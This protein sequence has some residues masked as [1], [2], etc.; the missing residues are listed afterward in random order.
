M[1]VM[2]S[3][4]ITLLKW[5]NFFYDFRPYEAIAVLYFAQVTGSFALGLAIFSVASIAAMIFE[6]PTGVLSDRI[7]RRKTVIFGSIASVLAIGFYAFGGS[8][9]MLAIGAV[10][11]GLTRAFLSGNNDALLYDTLKQ[12]G[13]TD[14]FAEKLGKVNSMFE[15]GL[16]VSALL[17]VGLAFISLQAVV[18]ASVVPQVICALIALKF[19]EPKV[20]SEKI[21]EN[22][23]AHLKEALSAFKNNLKLHKL[24]LA[25]VLDYAFE[26][27]YFQFKP[28]FIATL[29]PTWA[30]GISRAIDNLFGFLGYHYA[31]RFVKRF[32]A[33]KTL[34]AQ[35]IIGRIILF[36]AAGLPTVASPLLQNINAFF[37]GVGATANGDL[38]QKEFTDKQRATMGSLNSCA[39]SLAFAIVMFGVGLVA[40]QIGPA[41]TILVLAV[42]SVSVI[43]IYANLFKKHNT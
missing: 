27:A 16:G 39:G 12:E 28:A 36:V 40:D 19:I 2:V 1:N 30:L 11:N 5:Y 33:L 21:E 7:G 29:W 31:G 43:V 4:N 25:Y 20:H 26:E 37:F 23:F 32:G 3:K 35:Q 13:K 38:M 15:V 9:A 8:F 6:V 24:S 22:V 41:K 17:A 14:A 42:L 10:F 34:F 18:I